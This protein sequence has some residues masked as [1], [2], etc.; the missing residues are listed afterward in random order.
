MQSG[1]NSTH[2]T[3]PSIAVVGMGYW[4]KNLVRN[5]YDLGAL[6]AVCD[7]EKSVEENLNRE[8]ANVR[9][10]RE[11]DRVLDDPAVVAIALATPAVAHYE[12]ARAALNAGKDVFVEKPLAI[13]V[14]QGQELVEF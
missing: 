10:C 8:Y 11:F 6:Y 13:Q 7:S 1:S 2:Q 5:F 14:S 3:K 12:M 9:F 4:G